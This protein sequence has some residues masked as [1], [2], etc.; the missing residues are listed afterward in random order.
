MNFSR[1]RVFPTNSWLRFSIIFVLLFHIISWKVIRESDN[2]LLQ[3]GTSVVKTNG[4]VTANDIRIYKHPEKV[5]LIFETKA[6]MSRQTSPPPSP[7]GLSPTYSNVSYGPCQ[8]NVLDFWQADAGH[9]APLVIYIHGGGFSSGDKVQGQRGRNGEFLRRCLENGVSYA[10]I[11]YRF[12]DSARLDT[13]MLG[14]ARAVQFLRYK[15]EEWNIDKNKVGAFGGSAGGGA[16][17]WLA[18]H[19]DLADPENPDPVLRE[20]TR[21]QVAGHVNSQATY[22]FSRWAEVLGLSVDKSTEATAGDDLSLYHIPD[23]SWYNSPQIIELRKKVDMISMIDPADPPVFF[24]NPNPLKSPETRG[25]AAHHPRHAIFLK[26]K[27]EKLGLDHAI[28][29]RDTPEDERT[30][31]LDFFFK[32]LLNDTD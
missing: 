23:R 32:Y 25:E 10:S 22:D 5:R 7:A 30:D 28:V 9:P 20:S 31:M 11:N 4:L 2:E 12:K 3:S 14:I 15:S 21:L 24:F 1:K 19:D 29:L 16:S 13:I 8:R 26:N 17:I 27:Y 18:F 6:G